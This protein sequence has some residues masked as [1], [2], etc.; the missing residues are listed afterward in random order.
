MKNSANFKSAP[1]VDENCSGTG[2]PHDSSFVAGIDDMSTNTLQ[3]A[4]PNHGRTVKRKNRSCIE[5]PHQDRL[6]DADGNIP[7]R[8][9]YDVQ[10]VNGQDRI[11]KVGEMTINFS[12][13][14]SNAEIAVYMVL[15]A[16]RRLHSLRHNWT[17]RSGK[18]YGFALDS[19][20]RCTVTFRTEVD[21]GMIE[22]GRSRSDK[23]LKL[24]LPT[25]RTWTKSGLAWL[26][27]PLHCCPR[28]KN[29]P[30]PWLGRSCGCTA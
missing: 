20:K 19:N 22:A 27:A 25:P 26:G 11:F 7:Y 17:R 13:T 30:T 23:N 2:S 28:N 3:K 12:L 18:V 29:N 24:S 5:N 21:N 4:D 1:R 15:N 14:P 16:I 9:E 8:F 10:A 6:F